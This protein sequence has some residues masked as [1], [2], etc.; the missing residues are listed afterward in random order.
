MSGGPANFE[1]ERRLLVKRLSESGVIKESDPVFNALLKVPREEFVLS[2]MKQLAYQDTALPLTGSA[3][4]SQ[5]TTIAIMLEALELGKGKKVL[6]VGSGSGYVLA[7]LSEIVGKSGRVTGIEI[8]PEL[9]ERS[10]ALLA[11]LGFLDKTHVVEVVNSDGGAGFSRNAPYDAILVSAAARKVP[12]A[13]LK[14][15]K[16]NGRLV[17]PVGSFSWFQEMLVFRKDGKCKSLGR[18]A[19]VPLVGKEG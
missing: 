15:L 7:L 17:V 18:F 1:S 3:T 8:S 11:R 19:F 2:W 10:K 5:P 12:E 13:L 14:Q 16:K 9:S 4:I 6:E